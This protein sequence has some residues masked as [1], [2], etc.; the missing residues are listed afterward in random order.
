LTEHRAG[1][2]ASPSARVP[3]APWALAIKGLVA[4][5]VLA[6]MTLAV[7]W[8]LHV[9]LG[10]LSARPLVSAFSLI[11]GAI[12][13]VR[14]AL[15]LG[16]RPIAG[17][18]DEALPTVTV[19]VPAFNEGPRVVTT[20]ESLLGSDYPRERLRVIVVDDGSRDD[21]GPSLDAAFVRL[22][23]AGEDRL[24][25]I[26]LARNMGKRHAL[27][28]GFTRATSDIIATVDSDSLA[29]PGTLRALVAP[30]VDPKIGGVAGRVMV[31]NRYRNLMTR[32]LHVRYLLGFDFVRAYQSRLGTVWCCPGA[33]QAYRLE[34]VRPHLD[35][36]LH[37]RFLGARCTNGDDHALT[38]LVLSLG[39][40]TRY[41]STA[42]VYTLVPSTYSR[43]CKMYIRWG[44]SAT[45]EGWRALA[46]TPRRAAS[47]GLL[48][49]TAIALDALAQP[50]G[51]ALRLGSIG[52]G[53]WLA[54][55][56]PE[57]LARTLLLSTLFALP[58][59][60]VYLRS[61]RST[62][63][64]FGILYGWFALFGLFWVQPFATLTVRR[65]GWLTRK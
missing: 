65:N 24:E 38:N 21:T 1:P 5:G 32:M 39:Y 13:A 52:G 64:L 2:P 12:V 18:S 26:H 19:V 23:A 16:Y 50:L 51:I 6:L 61:E 58:Y 27:H 15:W 44:R 43:L 29:L 53:A 31:W 14:V 57:L 48:K 28:A 63:V 55:A 8:Q 7:L 10:S 35:A 49:G 4:L 36:W 40:D 30:F 20:V 22:R 11:F 54:L 37:Q 17:G 42:E 47:R 25:V 45:R 62:D 60:L 9:D 41:Q 33:L 46:F 3:D 56:H 59:A 34:T